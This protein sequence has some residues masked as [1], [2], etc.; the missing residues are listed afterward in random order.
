MLLALDECC[1]S[2]GHGQKESPADRDWRDRRA[3]V[4]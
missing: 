4:K 3:D 2:I 1:G